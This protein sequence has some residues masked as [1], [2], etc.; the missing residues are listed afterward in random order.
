MNYTVGSDSSVSGENW[1]T[2][3]SLCLTRLPFD[4]VWDSIPRAYF[5][6]K[7]VQMYDKSC[8]TGVGVGEGD[9]SLGVFKL[10]KSVG[11][12]HFIWIEA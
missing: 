10:E 1:V 7:S 12:L 6:F 9:I 8:R 5:H 3:G 4:K 11:S 2:S